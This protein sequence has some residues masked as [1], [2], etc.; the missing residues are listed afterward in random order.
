MWNIKNRSCI[1]VFKDYDCFKGISI[2]ISPNNRLLACGSSTGIV[3]LYEASSIF[4]SK[5]PKPLKLLPILTTATTCLKFNH[6]SELL[7]I[8]SS[9]KDKSLRLV[10]LVFKNIYYYTNY[11]FSCF[12]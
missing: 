1:H 6:S 3:N 2:T 4:Y 7:A 11:D 10:N 5:N 8:A 12:L 9:K